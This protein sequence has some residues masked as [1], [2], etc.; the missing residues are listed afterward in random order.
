MF[1]LQEHIFATVFEDI[2]SQ[3]LSEQMLLLQKDLGI[4]LSSINTIEGAC[5]EILTTLLNVDGI[6][7]G[8]IYLIDKESEIITLQ[9]VGGLSPQ[10]PQSELTIEYHSILGEVIQKIDTPIFLISNHFLMKYLKEFYM[11]SLKQ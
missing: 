7:A 1:F 10:K 5:D 8:A 11:R 4:A 2:S 6:N 3:K 9:T